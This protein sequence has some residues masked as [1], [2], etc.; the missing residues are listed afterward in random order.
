MVKTLKST[1]ES[2]DKTRV[3]VSGFES[4]V[5][6]IKNDLLNPTQVHVKMKPRKSLYVD[7]DNSDTDIPKT[8]EARQL[9]ETEVLHINDPFAGTLLPLTLTFS[10]LPTY[11]P[12]LTLIQC[13]R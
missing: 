8:E 7:E 10:Y 2:I 6:Q 9:K 4:R 11:L 5:D 12:P 3:S 13:L 1:S